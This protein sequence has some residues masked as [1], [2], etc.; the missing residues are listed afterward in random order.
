MSIVDI[1]LGDKESARLNIL[2]H[3]LKDS[4]DSNVVGRN[5]LRSNSELTGGL[6]LC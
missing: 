6:C 2:P 1:G 4:Q 3:G 5:L